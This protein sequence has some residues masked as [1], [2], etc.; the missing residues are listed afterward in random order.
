MWHFILKSVHC[1]K[2][3]KLSTVNSMASVNL[4][5]PACQY[6]TEKQW[7]TYMIYLQIIDWFQMK[8][9]PRQNKQSLRFYQML[10]NVK[11]LNKGALSSSGENYT[12]KS[13]NCS[14]LM[15]A[16]NNSKFTI[17]QSWP[18][19]KVCLTK[20]NILIVPVEQLLWLSNELSRY[21]YN[22]ARRVYLTINYYVIHISMH[23]K[24]HIQISE[25]SD[26]NL[27]HG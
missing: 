14:L 20:W 18:I 3:R 1:P 7:P 21:W 9:T 5:P 6:A 19:T 22:V 2:T 4:I 8:F 10:K 16:H 24:C 23:S 25:V 26:S 17:R 12:I 11:I 13:E 15:L 27:S